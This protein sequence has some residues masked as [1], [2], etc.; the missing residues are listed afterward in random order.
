MRIRHEQHGPL[1]DVLGPCVLVCRAVDCFALLARG[2]HPHQASE[3][4]QGGPH[5]RCV[6]RV[7]SHHQPD[8][9]G[10]LTDQAQH[11]LG[12][13]ARG[14][15]LGGEIDLIGVDREQRG[16]LGDG[17]MVSGAQGF[18][19]VIERRRQQVGERVDELVIQVG[20]EING[21]TRQGVGLYS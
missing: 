17:G 8:V 10:I 14:D 12:L 9:I 5:H 7:Q 3:H 2:L 11:L 19:C 1:G 20:G 16:H 13:G 6:L 18:L 15:A 4:G 21:R